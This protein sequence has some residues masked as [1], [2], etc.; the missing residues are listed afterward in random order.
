MALIKCRECGNEISD[1]AA[2]C[3]SCGAKQ[4][5]KMGF[6]KKALIGVAGVFVVLAVIGSLADKPPATPGSAQSAAAPAAAAAPASAFEFQTTPAELAGAYEA[7]TV[8]ADMR[9]KGKKFK[10]TGTVDS[11]NT[12]IGDGIYLTMRGGTPYMLP[13]FAL[14]DSEKGAAAALKKGQN[15]SLICTGGGDIA[16]IPMSRRCTFA[17]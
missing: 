7:N 14:V 16:K 10:V 17:S 13:Q 9:F 3:P 15:V 12:G 6:F 1:Q 2:A 5:K 8:A 11:I 4:K